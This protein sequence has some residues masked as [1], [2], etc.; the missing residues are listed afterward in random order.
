MSVSATP[1]KT[2]VAADGHTTVFS[3]QF[4]LPAGSTG[5]EV[6]V[7]VVD[8]LGN[9]TLLTSNYTINVATSQVSYPTVG[10]VD[11]L[12]TGINAVPAG[13]QIVMAR[14]EP[15][16]QNL[17]LTNQ[18]LYSLPA[19]EAALDYLMDIAQQLQEQLNRAVLLPI[20]Y[21][22]TS[23]GPVILPTTSVLPFYTGTLAQIIALSALNP[24][25]MANGYATDIN[26]GVGGFAYYTANVGVGNQGWVFPQIGIFG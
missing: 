21:P 25:Q 4:A 10:G 22:S 13:W 17:G 15:L 12:G 26:G 14:I 11:P 3:Y 18:G 6:N 16:A 19:I 7:F 2:I 24:T 1:S 5:T 9:V 20:N 23:A 8:N